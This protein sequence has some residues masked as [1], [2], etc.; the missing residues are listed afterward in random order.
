MKRDSRTLFFVA[1]AAV[2][3]IGLCATVSVATEETTITGRI[4]AQSWDDK[5][6]V[7]AVTITTLD[8][9]EYWIVDNPVG[10][11]L[12]KLDMEIVKV[13]GSL[14]KIDDGKNAITVNK[15]EIIQ[16]FNEQGN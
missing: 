8:G 2:L 16:G 5:F 12:L 10:K 13:T 3:A 7:T 14:S 1:L 11:E 6:E 4:W 15:Y 9:Q